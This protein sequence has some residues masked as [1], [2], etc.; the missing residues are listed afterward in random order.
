M[1][2]MWHTGTQHISMLEAEQ[3]M[4]C[5]EV[6][7]GNNMN[8]GLL[9]ELVWACSSCEAECNCPCAAVGKGCQSCQIAGADRSSL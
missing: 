6:A 7:C 1:Q 3:I 8:A 9:G 2:Q 4:L 5:V